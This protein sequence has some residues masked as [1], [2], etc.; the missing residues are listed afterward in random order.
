MQMTVT[1]SHNNFNGTEFN[2]QVEHKSV[3][4]SSQLFAL[5][6][7]SLLIEEGNTK[8]SFNLWELL[9]FELCKFNPKG[10]EFFFIII[11]IL[12]H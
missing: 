11:A 5:L 12:A 4:L 8:I 7:P 3:S 2:F 1:S 6:K 10:T 9:S